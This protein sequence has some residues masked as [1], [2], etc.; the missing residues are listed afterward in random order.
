MWYFCGDRGRALEIE[1]ANYFDV[2]KVWEFLKTFDVRNTDSGADD[3]DSKRK[4][5]GSENFD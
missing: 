4:T 5:H 1:V 3:R 2:E